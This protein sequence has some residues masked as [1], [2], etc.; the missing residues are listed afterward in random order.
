MPSQTVKNV[1]KEL[2]ELEKLG[3]R[4]TQKAIRNAIKYADDLHLNGMSVGEIASLCME[5]G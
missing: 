1:L 3:P 2:A 5:L 4:V